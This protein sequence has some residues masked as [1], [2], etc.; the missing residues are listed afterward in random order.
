[1]SSTNN[2]SSSSNSSR[3]SFMRS[4]TM[5]AFRRAL[6]MPSVDKSLAAIR[7]SS[8]KGLRRMSS[9]GKSSKSIPKAPAASAST[10]SIPVFTTPDYIKPTAAPPAISIS[11]LT[12]PSF[13]RA[14]T[15]PAPVRALTRLPALKKV[16]GIS[17]KA[18][19]VSTA[20]TD[21]VTSTTTSA[22]TSSSSTSTP[23]PR[24]RSSSI[25]SVESFSSTEDRVT[26][27]LQLR[28]LPSTMSGLIVSLLSV[29]LILIF[30]AMAAPAPRRYERK[31]LLSEEEYRNPPRLSSP[32]TLS[33]ISIRLSKA[34]RR[35]VRRAARARRA[36]SPHEAFAVFFK[37]TP[38][39]VRARTPAPVD[40][41]TLMSDVPLVVYSSPIALPLPKGPAPAV[42]PPRRKQ[43]RKFTVLPAVTEEEETISDGAVCAGW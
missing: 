28:A 13:G 5:P 36:S 16:C 10:E 37:R 25:A 3:P 17:R 34:Y 1:M 8:S 30:P 6:S 23:S 9:F 29:I 43:Q 2:S 20:S 32:S 18:S 22:S 33:R 31:I 38:K 24:R 12:R 7:Q 4:N 41:K 27:A 11:P 40:P 19:T 15:M 42:L 14:M 39:R 35:T 21:S 26:F